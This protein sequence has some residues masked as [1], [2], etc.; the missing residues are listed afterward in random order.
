MKTIISIMFSLFILP[1]FAAE[2]EDG[3]NFIANDIRGTVNVRCNDQGRARN[4]FYQCR[5]GFL[6]PGNYS[7]LVF[8]SNTDAD[9][10]RLTYTS[11]RGKER[12]KVSKVSDGI[13]R[14]INLWI[15]SLTQ[16]ALLK[17][18][19]NEI[20]YTLLKDKEAIEEGSFYVNVDSA[21]IRTCRHGYLNT[22]NN[23]NNSYAIC[24]EYFRKYNYCR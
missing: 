10:V 7:K 9:K 4:L 16:R 14:P 1:A 17:R 22:F 13:S 18:G 2:F 23:C 15:N 19:H 8:D 21:P 20:N 6:E 11:S 12:T 5:G 24:G 3:N